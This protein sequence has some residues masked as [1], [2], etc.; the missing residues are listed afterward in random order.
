VLPTNSLT[1]GPLEADGFQAPI[2]WAEPAAVGALARQLSGLGEVVRNPHTAPGW[3]QDAVKAPVLLERVA[4]MIGP[5]I[6]VEN[7]FAIVKQPGSPFAVPPHQDGINN[8][9]RLDPAASVAMWL[10]ITDATTE[11]GCLHVVPGSQRLG[12]LPYERHPDSTRGGRP[13]TISPGA[14]EFV[15]VPVAS[16]QAVAMDVRLL[17][18]S[19]PNRSTLPRIALNVR[20]LAPGAVTVLDGSDLHLFPVAGDRW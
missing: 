16:G 1:A 14:G 18:R 8:R 6:A 20:Y 7:T 19:H 11:N 15:P 13:L 5:D 9:H 12:Y 17:H 4:A 10:A 2:S 3:A